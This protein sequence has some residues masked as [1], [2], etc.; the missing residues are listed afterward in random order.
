M[1]DQRIVVSGTTGAGKTRLAKRI[2]DIGGIPAVDLDELHWG[3]DWTPRSDFRSATDAATSQPAWVVSGNYSAMRDLT[4]DR[5]NLVLWLNYPAP[6]VFWRLVR[7]TVGRIISRRPLF[8]G[9]RE[10]FRNTFLS[11]S[12][13]LVWFF[14]SHWSKRRTYRAVFAQ[15]EAEV[16]ELRKPKEAEAWLAAFAASAVERLTP[17]PF[18]MLQGY[19]S[20]AS[21]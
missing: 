2:A 1:A 19:P 14:K 8:G 18:R 13:I 15:L 10:T 12:S 4:W 11:P 21:E 16:I 17:S 3:P 7:R 9:N 6:L 20:G 5:A